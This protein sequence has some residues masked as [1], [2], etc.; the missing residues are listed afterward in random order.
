MMKRVLGTV[1]CDLDLNVKAKECIFVFMRL[2]KSLDVATSIFAGVCH[3]LFRVLD[4]FSCDKKPKV[5]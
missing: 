3:M 1:L 2:L 5:K 4:N